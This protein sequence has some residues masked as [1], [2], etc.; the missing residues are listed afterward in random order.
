[1]TRKPVDD[2]LLEIVPKAAQLQ[3]SFIFPKGP[4]IGKKT[5]RYFRKA[6]FQR[7]RWLFGREYRLGACVLPYG[8]KHKEKHR[9]NM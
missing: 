3:A 7:L 6:D 8:T 2:R 1:M 4:W 9:Y 5:Y